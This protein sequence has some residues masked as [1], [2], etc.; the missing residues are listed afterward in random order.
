LV[1]GTVALLSEIVIAYNT[2]VD[3]VEDDVRG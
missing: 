2:P 1:S 3:A